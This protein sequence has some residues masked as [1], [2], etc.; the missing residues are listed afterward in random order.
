MRRL[1]HLLGIHT[2]EERRSEWQGFD[3]T[4]DEVYERCMYCHT[5]KTGSWRLENING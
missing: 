5:P 1:L 2:W 3:V 4:A